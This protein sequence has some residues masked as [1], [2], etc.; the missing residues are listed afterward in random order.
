MKHYEAFN[1]LIHIERIKEKF[2]EEKEEIE[3]LLSNSVNE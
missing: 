1:M 3:S 2:P